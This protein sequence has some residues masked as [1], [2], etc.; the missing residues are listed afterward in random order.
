MTFTGA[1]AAPIEVPPRPEFGVLDQAGVFSLSL[2]K[3]TERVLE[4][5]RSL[6]QEQI[7]IYTLADPPQ[8]TLPE[9]AAAVADS[10]RRTAP[11]PP[12][13]VLIVV[14]AERGEIEIITGLGLDPVL[15]SARI[16]EIRKLVFQPEWRSARPPR[17]LVLSLVE[18]LRTLESPLVSSGEVTQA[19]ERAGFS[20]GWTPASPSERSWIGWVFTI[21]GILA[22][23]FVLLRTMTGEVHYT[24]MGWVRVT[25]LESFQRFFRR[26]RR[27][28]KTPSLVTGGGV[29]GSY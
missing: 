9:I 14:G 27:K 24:A 8:G 5:H 21:V 2:L 12:S 20:G 29:S 15:P 22:A 25:A 6:T 4:E 16:S 1:F 19:F 13:S 10:W 17:A 18:I 23:G 7:S 11:R 28:G 26:I 3:A